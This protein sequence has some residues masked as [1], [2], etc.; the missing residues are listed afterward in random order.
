MTRQST[1]RAGIL[2]THNAPLRLSTVST[3]EVGPREVLVRVHA[4]GVNPLDAKIHAGAAAHARHPLPAI[5]GIDLAGVVELTGRDVTRFKPGD[6]VYGMTGG[7]GGVPGSLAEFAAVDAD[8][9]APKPANLNMRETAAL[10]LI[11]ITAWEGLIDRAAL[12][13]GQ[14]VLIHGG[15]G[16]VGHVA[17]Q[18]A[19]AFEAD[20]FATGSAA[21]RATIE[22]FGAVFIDRGTAIE[23]YVAE[24][25]GGRGFDIVYDTV[26]GKVLDASFEAVRRFGHVV[27]AL[28]WGTHALAPLSFRAASYSGVFTLLPLLSGEGR[29]HH[30]EIMAEATRLVEAGKLAPLVDARRFTLESVGDAYALIRDHAAKGKLVVDI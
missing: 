8:L 13:A 12:K 24:H 6:E 15:A 25:T 26:G 10:P 27:S 4:S 21:Q 16:G 23:A 5:L 30:G 22:G 17:I 18:I 19:R 1:M 29:V 2:E 9:L 28:G 11:F 3:P 14:K 20:V 7:V